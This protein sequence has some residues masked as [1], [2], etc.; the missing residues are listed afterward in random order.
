MTETR[1]PRQ[2]PITEP[3]QRPNIEQ[4]QRPSTEPRQRL[5][6]EARQDEI[7][8]ATMDLVGEQ[9]FEQVTTQAIADQ[10]GLTQGAIFRHFASKDAI[11]LAVVR[12][13]R[14]R[15]LSAVDRAAAPARDPM[16]ALQ[17]IFFAHVAFAERHPAAPRL[18]MT[19]N[20]PVRRVLREMLDGYEARIA[21]LVAEAQFASLA[22]ADI[23]PAAA[24]AA[25]T[26]TI[27]G[28]VVRV[29]VLDTRPSM[30]AEAK[31]IW[32]LLAAGIA[33]PGWRP[34]GD[35]AT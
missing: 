35:A 10:I 12:W 26:A 34:E 9:G 7:V 6:T 31:R 25:F 15:L 2:R 16:D 5:S 30:T 14:D 29:L 11:W 32:P 4:R 27:Q 21:A 24:A 1:T 3:R 8:R 13:I 18:L 28:L 23:D 33:A 20:A 17:R 19:T 22:R